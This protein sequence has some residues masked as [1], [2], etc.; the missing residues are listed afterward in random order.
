MTARILDISEDD[1]HLRDGL[2][3]SI[4]KE[5]VGRSALHGWSA[6][7]KHGARGR[8]PTKS[9]DRG[10]VIHKLVLGK[11]KGFEVLQF[12]D[13]KTKAAQQARDESRGRGLIPILEEAFADA[14]IAAEKI[15]VGLADRDIVLDGASEVAIEWTES[16]PDGDVLCR[17]MLDHLW[18]ADGRI[19]DLKVVAS[20]DPVS[21]ERSAENY[22]YAIQACAYTRALVALQPELAGRSEFLFAFCEPEEPHAMN[23]CRPDGAFRELG[24][25][26]WLRAVST[27]STCLKEQRWPSY[28]DGI[29]PLSVPGWALAREDYAA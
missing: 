25:R 11:G 20:A 27:W 3:S 21:V 1:Y 13:Y 28:G 14:N 9:M 2:S 29:N 19:L 4:A 7:P 15:R 10:T 22:G 23:I 18:I 6:H 8:S 17:G 24:E 26:R 5:V 12:G 16:A